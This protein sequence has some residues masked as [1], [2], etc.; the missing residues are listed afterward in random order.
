MKVCPKCHSTFTDDTLSF[1]LTDG[2]PLVSTGTASF[3]SSEFSSA[4]TI[5]ESDATLQNPLAH[6]TD[7]QSFSQ[8]T[9]LLTVTE[10]PSERGG[11]SRPK[12]AIYSVLA[13]LL[14]LGVLGGG[15]WYFFKDNFRQAMDPPHDVIKSDEAKKVASPLT[16]EQAAQIQKEVQD[17]LNSWKASIEKRDLNDQM[18]HYAKTVETFYRDSDKDQNSVRA[19]RQKAIER[20]DTL[21]LDLTNI[22]VSTESERFAKVVFDKTWVFRGKDRFSSGSVQ[23]EMG[24]VKSDGKWYIVIEKDLQIYSMNNRQT[25]QGGSNTNSN[26]PA[27]NQ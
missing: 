26:A 19:E 4:D 10:V 18:R 5:F 6:V 8:P 7:S 1:C 11:G 15:G 23:Q 12:T 2:T 9:Q 20:F 27:A 16:P 17:F 14:V 3:S 22:T 13:T 24:L 25:P 21:N